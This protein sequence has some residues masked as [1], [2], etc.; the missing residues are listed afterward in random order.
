MVNPGE[1]SYMKWDMEGMMGLAGGA[2]GMMNMKVSNPKVETVLD[3]AGPTILGCTTRHVKIQTSYTMSMSFMG[4]NNTS[5]IT[6]EQELWTT[7]KF[8]DAGLDAWKNT[9]G[10]LK[11][12]DQNLD[13]LIKA[14]MEKVQGIPLKMIA[15]TTNKD[16]SGKSHVNRTIMEVTEIKEMSVSKDKF[17]IP[18]GYTEKKMEDMIPSAMKQSLKGAKSGMSGGGQ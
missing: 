14:Q 6:Q 9:Q 17:E 15:S 2:M 11:T 3:E 13:A 5:S 4:M 8:K 7:E 16:N 12:G 18:S 10:M 1:K